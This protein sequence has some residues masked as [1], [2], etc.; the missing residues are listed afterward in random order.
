MSFGQP[1]MAVSRSL[2]A[3][4]CNGDASCDIA[5]ASAAFL[6]DLC[7]HACTADAM[8][9]TG[10]ATVPL[11]TY[12]LRLHALFDCEPECWLMAMVYIRRLCQLQGGICRTSAHKLLLTSLLLAVKFHSDLTLTNAHYSRIGGVRLAVLNAMEAQLLQ[13]LEWRVAVD[14]EELEACRRALRAS[15]CAQHFESLAPVRQGHDLWRDAN[16]PVCEAQSLAPCMADLQEASTCDILPSLATLNTAELRP[17]KA[18]R[19]LS[20]CRVSLCLATRRR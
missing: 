19:W 5:L 11:G 8:F 16:G 18:H 7:K 1:A 2:P 14:I 10:C 13:Q 12:A 20:S 6:E 17:R 15:V 4:S 3:A 9:R